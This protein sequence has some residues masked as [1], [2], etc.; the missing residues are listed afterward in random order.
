MPNF[1]DHS[2]LENKIST[3]EKYKSKN[4][5]FT[6]ILTLRRGRETGIPPMGNQII[7]INFGKLC[8]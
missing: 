2:I 7:I 4:C 8:I 1:S 6:E 5:R 3:A